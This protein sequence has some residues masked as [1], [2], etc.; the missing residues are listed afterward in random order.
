MEIHLE[1]FWGT[2]ASIGYFSFALYITLL[3][4]YIYLTALV[5]YQINIQ[6]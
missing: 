3:L 5:N 4:F 6:Q 2:C 1:Q